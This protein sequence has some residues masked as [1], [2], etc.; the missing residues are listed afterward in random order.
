MRMRKGWRKAL[1]A[2]SVRDVA[3]AF[4]EW[5]RRYRDEP[6]RFQSEAEHLLR[7]TPR[8]YGERVA[9]YFLKVLAEVV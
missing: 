7:D 9:L 1:D 2:A 5:D 4:E 3:A 8:T 6:E